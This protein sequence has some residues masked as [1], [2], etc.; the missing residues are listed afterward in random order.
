MPNVMGVKKESVFLVSTACRSAIEQIGF[1][2]VLL[3]FFFFF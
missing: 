2:F 1:I 3:C